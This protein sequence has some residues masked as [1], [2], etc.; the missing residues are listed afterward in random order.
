MDQQKEV[1]LD[2]KLAES[3]LTELASNNREIAQE[4]A[5]YT[6]A[7][8]YMCNMM[9]PGAKLPTLVIEDKDDTGR[10]VEVVSVPLATLPADDVNIIMTILMAH[11]ENRAFD[12]W[13]RQQRV[14]T[15][16]CDRV[17]AMTAKRAEE[18][19]QL[20]KDNVPGLGDTEHVYR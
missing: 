20:T 2:T 7:R 4:I 19:R 17:N 10:P 8:N 14:V 15:A 5:I 1:I 6:N 18:E 13:R 16:G 3:N 12:S 9:L 11:S